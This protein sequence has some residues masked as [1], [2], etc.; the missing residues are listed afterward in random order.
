VLRVLARIVGI[1]LFAIAVDFVLD[2]A[3]AFVEAAGPELL[4]R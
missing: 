4:L 1:L 3:K 2:G